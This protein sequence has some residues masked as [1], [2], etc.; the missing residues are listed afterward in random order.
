MTGHHPMLQPTSWGPQDEP[1]EVA[2]RF[3]AE[4]A[5]VY[6]LVWH[7]AL[8]CALRPPLL[9]HARW[10]WRL[11]DV[12]LAS[13]SR[14]AVLGK[15]GYWL[16]RRDWPRAPFPVAS[17]ALPAPT[18]YTLV[19]VW[20]QPVPA[21]T[22][23]EFLYG[24]AQAG[25]ATASGLAGLW[26]ELTTASGHREPYLRLVA[27]EQDGKAVQRVELTERAAGALV[28]WQSKGLTGQM[29]KRN[30]VLDAVA[31][32]EMSYRDGARELAGPDLEQLADRFC[33]QVDELCMRW[34]GLS[35]NEGLQ[36]LAA[37]QTPPPRF[38]GLPAWLDPEDVLPADHP[39]RA[40]RVRMEAQLAMENSAWQTL[41]E[42]QRGHCRL[43]WLK[44]HRGEVQGEAASQLQA[45]LADEGRFS[46][47]RYWLTGL[48]GLTGL[49][50]H[51]T[52]I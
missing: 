8:A 5:R 18:G 4:Q 48:T 43:Q 29:F 34:R 26:E 19:N 25:I 45:A 10:V 39:L 24:I 31:A 33:R 38:T 47:L 6:E 52:T 2:K 15:E 42:A 50:R 1:K 14:Q 9:Q 51:P 40:L 21:P 41:S 35:R 32:G 23:G 11:D 46:A 37:E 12:L 49:T 7:T 28:T 22:V 44:A 13:A 17:T 3:G 30:Q 27:G 20:T 16:E 36:A